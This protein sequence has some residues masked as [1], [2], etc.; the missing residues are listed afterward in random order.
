MKKVF[1]S[2]AIILASLQF[3]YTILDLQFDHYGNKG[4]YSDA[5]DLKFI[6]HE[7]FHIK[8]YVKIIK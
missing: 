6:N 2:T 8:N 7:N 5:K 3:F 4:I 1:I